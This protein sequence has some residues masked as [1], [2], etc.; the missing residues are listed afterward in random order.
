[1][2]SRVTLSFGTM[3]TAP[4]LRSSKAMAWR[5][6]SLTIP[7]ESSGDRSVNKV[8]ITG[9]VTRI[10]T[11]PKKPISAAVTATIAITRAAPRL[12]RK[13]ARPCNEP[14]PGTRLRI[15]PRGADQAIIAYGMVS[16]WLTKVKATT[17]S[18][19]PRRRGLVTTDVCVFWESL[20]RAADTFSI[21]AALAMGPRLGGD[22]IENLLPVLLD[23]RGAQAGE[24]V[25]VD[26]E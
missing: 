19:S 1:M 8:V 5:S 6:R 24:A 11:K 17:H 3:I 12:F 25:L 21:P 9:E 20:L 16:I 15:R 4:S 13:P 2:R 18:S 7:A 23:A 10:M 14:A 26:G 22:D